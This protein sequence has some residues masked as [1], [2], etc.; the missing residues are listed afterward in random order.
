MCQV[1]ATT[2]LLNSSSEDVEGQ[3]SAVD[4][5]NNRWMFTRENGC[6]VRRGG[7]KE[8]QVIIRYLWPVTDVF[9]LKICY[10][11]VQS[12][13]NPASCCHSDLRFEIDVY[14]VTSSLPGDKRPLSL[15]SRSKL[16]PSV[17]VST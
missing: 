10:A 8:S 1:Y 7:E 3:K 14:V 11:D 6:D 4:D 17:N 15:L 13:K 12:C 5:C 16:F 2:V 9:Q